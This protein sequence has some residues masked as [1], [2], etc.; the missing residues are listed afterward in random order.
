MLPQQSV[1]SNRTHNYCNTQKFKFKGG[2]FQK[3]KE[4]EPHCVKVNKLL[5]DE[6]RSFKHLGSLGH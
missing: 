6:P 2:T 5:Q 1:S 4:V 3:K